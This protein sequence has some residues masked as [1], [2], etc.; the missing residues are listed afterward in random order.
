[1]LLICIYI[2]ILES[3]FIDFSGEPSKY[4][5]LHGTILEIIGLHVQG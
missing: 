5:G 2:L 3:G 4:H 1:M